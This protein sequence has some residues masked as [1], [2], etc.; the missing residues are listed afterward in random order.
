MI[1][2]SIKDKQLLLTGNDILAVNV[3]RLIKRWHYSVDL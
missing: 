3:N 1:Y 2:N